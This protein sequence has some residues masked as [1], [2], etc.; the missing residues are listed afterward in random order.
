[1]TQ[2]KTMIIEATDQQLIDNATICNHCEQPLS[3]LRQPY[4]RDHDHYT[5]KFL[6]ESVF[7]IFIF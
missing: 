3:V 1:M 6:G 2:D 7:F 5:G 4:V